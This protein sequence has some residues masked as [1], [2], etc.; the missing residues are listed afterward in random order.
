MQ[1]AGRTSTLLSNVGY[2]PFGSMNTL[3]YGNGNIQTLP[4]SGG[5]RKMDI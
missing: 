5:R 2:L 4:D 3:T 1:R